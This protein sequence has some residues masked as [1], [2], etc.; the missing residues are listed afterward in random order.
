[1]DGKFSVI[2]VTPYSF[3]CA[4]DGSKNV[5]NREWSGCD[6]AVAQDS[7]MRDCSQ[8]EIFETSDP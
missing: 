3:C 5:I 2:T 4:D 6:R 7:S 1:M 8:N